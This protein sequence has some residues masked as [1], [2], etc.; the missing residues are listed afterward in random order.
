[1][2]HDHNLVQHTA[3]MLA[4]PGPKHPQMY[5]PDDIHRPVDSSPIA[6]SHL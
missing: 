2:D 6:M 3:S 4:H 1:M 5:I